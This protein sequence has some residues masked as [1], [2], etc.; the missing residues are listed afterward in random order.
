MSGD[1]FDSLLL[2]K[3]GSKNLSNA[4]LRKLNDR[5]QL[6]RTHK[7]LNKSTIAKGMA[8]VGAVVGTM[9]TVLALHDNGSRLI[10]IGKKMAFDHKYKQLRIRV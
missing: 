5:Q 9:G 3:R 2:K 10:K 8:A 7:S 4:E 1:A 6:E